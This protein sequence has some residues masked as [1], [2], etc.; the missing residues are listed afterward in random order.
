MKKKNEEAVVP[1][2]SV[3]TLGRRI[4][5]KPSTGRVRGSRLQFNTGKGGAPG[6]PGDWSIASR[7][8][9]PEADVIVAG[10]VCGFQ[11]AYG[12]KACPEVGNKVLLL[13]QDVID[14]GG[15]LV[16][17]RP[18]SFVPVHC[19]SGLVRDDD[20]GTVSLGGPKNRYTIFKAW[21]TGGSFAAFDEVVGLA[22]DAAEAAGENIYEMLWTV[23]SRSYEHAQ[24]GTVHVPVWK[25][26]GNLPARAVKDLLKLSA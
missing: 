4:G 10:D 17:G 15:T 26:T 19:V 5:N 25:C 21:F 2:N 7:V 9:G 22:W 23:S 14:A 3:G 12:V 11:R 20:D 13:E 18:N 1:M 8:L 6:K 24:Y 16:A